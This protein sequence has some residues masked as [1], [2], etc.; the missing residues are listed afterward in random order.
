LKRL[1]PRVRASILTAATLSAGLVAALTAPPTATAA[2]HHHHHHAAGPSCSTFM[3]TGTVEGMT[4]VSSKVYGVVKYPTANG[5]P[6]GPRNHVPGSICQWV[7]STESNEGLNNTGQILVGYGLT[8]KDWNQLVSFYKRGAEDGYPIGEPNNPTYSPLQ[9][10]HGSKAFL[11][12]A[13]LGSAP[14]YGAA[15]S[16][17][18][19]SFLYAVTVMTRRHNLAQAWFYPGTAAKTQA[20]VIEN[21]LIKDAHFF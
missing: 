5:V 13:P 10:G 8:A 11:I 2:N 19:P 17:G 16:P 1:F 7:R 3:S 14:G 20:W 6:D 9:L 18:F 12:T 15:E 21:I 4:G